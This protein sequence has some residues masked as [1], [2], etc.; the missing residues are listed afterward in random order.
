MDIAIDFGKRKSYVVMDGNNK[1]ICFN[2]NP[3][4]EKNLNSVKIA[5]E[6]TQEV[7]IGKLL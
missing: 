6:K 7:D 5:V 2:P 1:T 4:P 3:R